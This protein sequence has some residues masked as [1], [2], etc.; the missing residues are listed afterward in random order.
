MDNIKNIKPKEVVPGI[1]GHYAHGDGL[2]F[3]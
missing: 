2:T 1:T 3:G